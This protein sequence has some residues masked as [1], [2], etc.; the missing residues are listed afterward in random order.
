MSSGLPRRP[1]LL[2]IPTVI[3]NKI[4]EQMITNTLKLTIEPRTIK[5]ILVVWMNMLSGRPFLVWY[6]S[7][8]N[9]DLFKLIPLNWIKIKLIF[10]A[11]WKKIRP[12]HFA[13]NS[14]VFELRSMVTA[15][16]IV[17][18]AKTKMSSVKVS[19]THVCSFFEYKVWGSIFLM[20]RFKRMRKTIRKSSI[21]ILLTIILNLWSLNSLNYLNTKEFTLW[22][23][24]LGRP[25]F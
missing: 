24:D 3:I 14:F 22:R 13:T 21:M 16:K 7:D 5:M 19:Q 23:V 10:I 4:I 8:S 6:P 9:I 11:N 17:N 20:K 18:P 15:L 25:S 1:S 12:M 2:N